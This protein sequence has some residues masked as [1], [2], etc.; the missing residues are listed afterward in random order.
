MCKLLIMTGISEPLLAKEFMRR[1][2]VPMSK[3]NRDGIGYTAVNNDGSMFTERW[4]INNQFLSY[5]SIMTS[6]VAEQLL[7]FVNRLPDGALDLNYTGDMKQDFSNVTSLT[8]HTRWAT[9]AKGMENTHPFVYEDTSLIHNGHIS[10]WSFLNVNKI[11]D[12]DSEAALQTYINAGVGRDFNQYQE[13][14]NKLYG[15]YAFGILSRD[16]SGTRVLDVVR[17]ESN[18]YFMQIEGLGSIFTTDNDDAILVA[19]E[20]GLEFKESPAMIK[21][22]TLYRFNATTG[23]FIQS[24]S[25]K[26]TTTS[27][28]YGNYGG[29]NNWRG[30]EST[31]NTTSLPLD[32]DKDKEYNKSVT[33]GDQ[34]EDDGLSFLKNPSGTFNA[35][36]VMAHCNNY[37]ED[38]RDRLE[39]HDLAFKSSLLT[40]FESL[41]EV[42]RD[43]IEQ[44]D[45][46]KG[47]KEAK[48]L[49]HDFYKRCNSA[50]GV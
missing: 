31:K 2:A 50:S 11:S 24:G 46:N 26:T 20:M 27:Y 40:K 35:V 37:V 10:N 13:W 1:M 47:F 25:I 48:K 5:D 34:T 8:M 39:I 6:E 43:F 33:G 16:A 4:L 44:E 30:S 41:S 14:L 21:M 42:A 18:L 17:G 36:K 22:N 12:C 9:T 45:Y 15:R 7:P 23:K 29:Y 19:K 28:S 3:S 32:N 38:F 49:I